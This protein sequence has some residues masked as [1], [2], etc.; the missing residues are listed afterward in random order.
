MRAAVSAQP[1]TGV[2]LAGCSLCSENIPSRV[3]I[4]LMASGMF[5]TTT[6]S[7]LPPRRSILS[8][9]VPQGCWVKQCVAEQPLPRAVI[10][11]NVNVSAELEIFLPAD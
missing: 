5:Q 8:S 2:A 3:D 11:S 9:S 1:F 7:V 4:P 6:P 10:T